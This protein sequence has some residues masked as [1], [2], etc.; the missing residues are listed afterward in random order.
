MKSTA[1]WCIKIW[2]MYVPKIEKIKHLQY[3]HLQFYTLSDLTNIN[4]VKSIY[5][6][7]GRSWFHEIS[8]NISWEGNSAISNKKFS[9]IRKNSWNQLFSNFFSA[10]CSEIVAFTNVLSKKKSWKHMYLILLFWWGFLISSFHRV[11]WFPNC[12]N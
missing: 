5:R 4:Y 1:I 9:L 8:V 3:L 7:Y 6:F 10:R 2:I 11:L 12:E